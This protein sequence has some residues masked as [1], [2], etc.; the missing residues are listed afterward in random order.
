MNKRIAKW[1]EEGRFYE[2]LTGKGK[3][4]VMN[5]T[6]RSHHDVLLVL[7]TMIEW[8]FGTNNIDSCASYFTTALNRI[9][10]ED[11]L[12][13]LNIINCYLIATEGHKDPKL[14]MKL[15]SFREVV[16]QGLKIDHR[17]SV[18]K[19]EQIESLL[20]TIRKTLPDFIVK[21]DEKGD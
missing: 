10:K 17:Y 12:V 1:F 6:Y 9:C 3:Y 16:N 7:Y 19:K 21:R 8:A 11:P 4:F 18:E 20:K 13:G 15:E 2:A 5:H 14:P